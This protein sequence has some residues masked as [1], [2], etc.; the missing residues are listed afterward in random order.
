[1]WN[2]GQHLDGFNTWDCALVKDGILSIN[3]DTVNGVHKSAMISSEYSFKG[4]LGRYEMRCRLNPVNGSWVDIWLYTRLM[5]EDMEAELP[6]STRGQEIDLFEARRIDKNGK[7]ISHGVQHTIHWDGYGS[8]YK[9]LA[10]FMGTNLNDSKFHIFSLLRTEK[11][12]IFYIDGVETWRASP[13]CDLPLFIIVSC[14]LKTQFWAGNLEDS[15]SQTVL[16]V[17]YIRY[18]KQ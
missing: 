1:M 8:N 3:V 4:G 17:D 9:S 16:E 2:E 12:N 5:A 15:Y 11:E 7:N 18:F 6:I 13:S 10:K 14:E